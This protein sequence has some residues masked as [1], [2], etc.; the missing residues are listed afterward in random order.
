MAD[1]YEAAVDYCARAVQ[2]RDALQDLYAQPTRDA[3][4][5]ASLNGDL[6]DAMKLAEVHA[7]L[8]IAQRLDDLSRSIESGGGVD[9]VG[10]M[11]P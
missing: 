10:L 5:V 3:R 1:H 2:A 4:E 11:R 6:G 8:A 7:L 9:L